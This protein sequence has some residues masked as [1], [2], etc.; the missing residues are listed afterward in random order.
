MKGRLLIFVFSMVIPKILIAGTNCTPLGEADCR[1]TEGCEWASE[2]C[3]T[4]LGSDSPNSQGHYCPRL[5]AD[6]DC[7]STT[8]ACECPSNF[9][10]STA[11]ATKIGDCYTPCAA[12]S[13]NYDSYTKDCGLTYLGH[14]N[15]NEVSCKQNGIITYEQHDENYHAE[16][17]SDGAYGCYFKHRQCSDF[18]T[19]TCSG[20][21]YGPAEWRSYEWDISN[22]EC[23]QEEFPDYTHSCNAK[24]N[25]KPS[26]STIS[27][28]NVPIN[29]DTQF[30]YWC[31]SCFSG[32]Y[33]KP[34]DILNAG[35]D[36]QTC[37]VGEYENGGQY[38]VCEC[39]PAPRGTWIDS[40]NITYP[41]TNPNNIP[42]STTNCPTGKTTSSTGSTSI[43]DCHYT[44]QTKF[45]DANGCFNIT[46]AADGGWN[47]DY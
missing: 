45:C 40:C 32:Y 44:N 4:C 23:N 16:P 25:K 2:A 22:C 42:C 41:I 7:S 1:E 5:N 17:L 13:D 27:G 20:N 3:I 6:D 38:A 18:N 37:I 35:G 39:T 19:N 12:T 10:R 9:P 28:V 31:V 47:W 26:A 36:N 11:G 43:D 15:A 30:R 33:V 21:I 34:D 29:Y 14:Y 8:G 46:D 24:R